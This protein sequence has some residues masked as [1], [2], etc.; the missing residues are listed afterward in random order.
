MGKH[1]REIL[2][3]VSDKLGVAESRE[4][5]NKSASDMVMKM[6]KGE[7]VHSDTANLSALYY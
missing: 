4:G 7:K 3:A 2:N 6:A 5:K 1:I